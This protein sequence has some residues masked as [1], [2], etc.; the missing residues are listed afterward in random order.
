MWTGI[1]APRYA[2][3]IDLVGI[4]AIAPAADMGRILRE[5]QS[6]N[7]RLGPYI[8][9]AYSRFYPDVEFDKAIR[10]SA[11]A[12]AQAIAELCGFADAARIAEIVKS[13][14]GPSLALETD[15]ALAA[16]I[17]EN[18][19]DRMISQPILVAQGLTDDVV[20]PAYTDDYVA[21]RCAAGQ[22]ITY[23]RI[24]G[25]DHGG[26]VQPESPL[27]Q[28]LVAWTAARFAGDEPP[29]SCSTQLH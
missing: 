18:K 7:T 14:G 12:G 26:I 15:K 17:A 5:N 29:K 20:L 1:V 27:S 13:I 23:L 8:A 21:E 19:A 9:A 25:R 6:V 4:A 11:L 16:R 2:P 24:A 3:E 10:P 28:P 22:P